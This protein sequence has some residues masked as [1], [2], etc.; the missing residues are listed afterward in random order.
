[1][2]GHE[3]ASFSRA[4]RC[5]PARIEVF[6]L[7]SGVP[8]PRRLGTVD[9]VLLGGSGDY[10]V[11][12]GGAWLPAALEAM[13]ELHETSK[14]T[15]A[16]CWGFQAMARAMG[17]EVVTDHALA[18]VGSAWLELTPE[19]E[20]DPVFGPLGKRFPVQI[21]HQDVVTRLPEGATLL[22]SS[23]L[24]RNEAFRFEG[25][26]IY[27]TQFHPELDKAGLIA[28]LAAYPEYLP[29]AGVRTVEELAR[30]TP[31]TPGTEALLRRFLEHVLG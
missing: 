9:V 12:E 30:V 6:D 22:A 14:P 28:R 31:D 26:P 18:E 11:A 13:Q 23:P 8:S 1:M 17:G 10:S 19:G 20:A 2:R 25:K 27:C 5:D 15:F 7:L 3:I 24:V 16:S 21:G 29:L 4:F